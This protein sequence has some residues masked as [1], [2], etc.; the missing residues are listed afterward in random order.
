MTLPVS[1]T[2]FKSAFKLLIFKRV[3]LINTIKILKT[4][5]CAY[6]VPDNPRDWKAYVL[7][8]NEYGICTYL[9]PINKK[10]IIILT[11]QYV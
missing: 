6:T 11:F 3:L 4:L 7:T 10:N 9:V 2:N 8:P 5:K 1:K